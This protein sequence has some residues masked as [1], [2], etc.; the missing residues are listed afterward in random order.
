VLLVLLGLIELFVRPAEPPAPSAT[1][2]PAEN[3]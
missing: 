3:G 2:G 1:A